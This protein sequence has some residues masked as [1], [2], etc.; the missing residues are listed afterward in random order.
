MHD[1]RWTGS[2]VNQL[3][4]SIPTEER[5]PDYGLR[6]YITADAQHFW[7]YGLNYASEHLSE[8]SLINHVRIV[9][10]MR[11]DKEDYLGSR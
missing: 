5:D 10:A 9:A 11:H 8:W 1:G 4:A 2:A 3:M 7:P 6:D